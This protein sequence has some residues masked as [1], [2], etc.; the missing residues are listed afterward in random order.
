MGIC[1][2]QRL[3]IKL[4]LFCRFYLFK[5]NYNMMLI[6]QFESFSPLDLQTLCAW[7]D[8]NSTRKL[9]HSPLNPQAFYFA[10]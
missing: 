2:S 3:R 6:P 10:G 5:D 4:I 9:A 1:P 7:G 8:T